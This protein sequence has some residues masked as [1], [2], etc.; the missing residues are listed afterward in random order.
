MRSLKKIL[1]AIHNFKE[2]HN[3]KLQI[4]GVVAALVYQ[5]TT[6][7]DEVLQQCRKYCFENGIH[8]FETVILRSVRFAA[9]VAY[10]RKPATLTDF[11]N[12]LVKVILNY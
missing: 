9:S 2:Q 5:R 12:P 8:M 6:L 7:H 1:N 11:K 10:D 3:P 4:T